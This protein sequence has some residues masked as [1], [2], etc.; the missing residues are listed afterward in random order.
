MNAGLVSTLV[1][2]VEP[3]G[4]YG[5]FAE[6]VEVAEVA[7]EKI[8]VEELEALVDKVGEVGAGAAEW[9]PNSSYAQ[10][11]AMMAMITPNAQ[12]SFFSLDVI[13]VFGYLA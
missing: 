12:Y 4:R 13:G 3:F 10:K 9:P 1:L 2:K 8:P 5:K 11:I 7:P 6:F